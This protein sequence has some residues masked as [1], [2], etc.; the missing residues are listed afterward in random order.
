MNPCTLGWY[1]PLLVRDAPGALQ[2]CEN[3]DGS[4]ERERNGRKRTEY[5]WQ[6]LDSKFRRDLP[7][8]AYVGRLAYRGLV[9][10]ACPRIRMLDG[11]EVSEKER[12]K[13]HHLL[14]GIMGKS[15]IKGIG[16]LGTGGEADSQVKS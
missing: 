2:P 7:D 8:D 4:S 14:Q 13:A 12:T 5:G 10:R 9:M 15:K 3:Q 6:E 11:V 16:K 1:L